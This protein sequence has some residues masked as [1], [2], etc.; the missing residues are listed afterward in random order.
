ML[1]EEEDSLHSPSAGS[2]FLQYIKHDSRESF[3]GSIIIELEL[4]VI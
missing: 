2:G 4:L 3:I 1:Q